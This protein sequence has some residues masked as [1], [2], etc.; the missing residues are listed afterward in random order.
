[1]LKGFNSDIR[2]RGQSFHVQTEDWGAE[3]ALLV[4][5]VF[6][7]GAVVKTLKTPYAEALRATSVRT[8]EALRAALQKQHAD[9]IDA[10]MEGRLTF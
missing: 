6:R 5:R 1:M 10:I 8:A 4:T 9:V 3:K 2:A 7:D